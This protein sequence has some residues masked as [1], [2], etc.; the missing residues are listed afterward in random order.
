LDCAILPRLKVE[1]LLERNNSL[2]APKLSRL[3]GY[4]Q[5]QDCLRNGK[6]R[7]KVLDLLGLAFNYCSCPSRL[8]YP[9]AQKIQIFKIAGFKDQDWDSLSE[10][11]L[12]IISGGL[13]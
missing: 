11:K 5:P 3:R 10:H 12:E 9:V 4:D 2:F 13:L 7:C 1:N 8:L 6:I